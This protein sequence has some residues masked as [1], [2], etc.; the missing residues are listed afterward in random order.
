MRQGSACANPLTRRSYSP[1][2]TQAN[3]ARSGM[4]RLLATFA[5]EKA[6]AGHAQA[7]K[8]GDAAGFGNGSNGI[9]AYV[10][11]GI[12]VVHASLLVQ[13]GRCEEA[14]EVDLQIPGKAYYYPIMRQLFQ[15]SVFLKMGARND[16]DSHLRQ[17]YAL[18]T[19]EQA[20]Y[21]KKE[22]DALANQLERSA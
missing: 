13:E 20:D 17:A 7:D 14:L 2:S 3:T 8:Q 4:H 5:D 15:T 12:Q 16:T 21:Y 18:I 10:L 1:T 6:C 9:S 11:E 19:A 22:A